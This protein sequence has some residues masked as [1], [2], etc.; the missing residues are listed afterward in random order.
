MLLMPRVSVLMS[1]YRGDKAEYLK[2]ALDSIINQTDSVND[3]VIMQDGPVD[4]DVRQ[5]LD[6]YKKRF[7]MVQIVEKHKNEGLAVSLCQGLAYTKNELVARM[8]SDDVSLPNRISLQL[9]EFVVHP[10]VSVVSADIA[11]FNDDPNTIISQR[12]LPQ[13]HEELVAFAQKR[14]P[15]N[16]PAVMYKKTAVLS[17]GNYQ[18]FNQLEDYHLWVRMILQGYIFRNIPNSLVLM[19]TGAGLYKRRGGIRYLKQY[20][21]LRHLFTVWGFSNICQEIVA[22]LFMLANIILPSKLRKIA[23]KVFLR[24]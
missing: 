6:Q 16:H 10:E 21:R 11:E 22:D 12:K 15:V 20:W 24:K 13:T 3:I 5:L 18:K 4:E 14:S 23:Y 17:S 2:E 1:V 19:R 8:D 7:S 9:Q